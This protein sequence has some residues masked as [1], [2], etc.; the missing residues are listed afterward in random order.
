MHNIFITFNL[1]T[2][3]SIRTLVKWKIN[4]QINS[5][6][7]LRILCFFVNPN[8]CVIYESIFTSWNRFIFRQINSHVFFCSS[9]FTKI[10]ELLQWNEIHIFSVKVIEREI[11]SL[12]YSLV[13]P[14]LSRNFCQESMTVISKLDITEISF[15]LYTVELPTSAFGCF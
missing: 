3:K 13:K 15:S 1:L 9:D 6:F 4:R 12:V 5:N 10:S 14:L 2:T 7:A 11:N 8:Q